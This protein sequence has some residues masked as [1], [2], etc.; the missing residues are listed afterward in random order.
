VRGRWNEVESCRTW[1]LS[2][3]FWHTFAM[4]VQPRSVCGSGM[5]FPL[6]SAG[7]LSVFCAMG[8]VAQEQT[9]SSKEEPIHT[10]HVYTNLI[11]VP[12]LVLSGNRQPVQTPISEKRFSVSIDYGPWF[13]VTHVRPEGND[14]ISISFLLDT[15]APNLLQGIANGIADLSPS[16]LTARDH[17]SIYVMGCGLTRSLNDVPVAGGVLKDGVDSAMNAWK[18]R[19]DRKDATCKRPVQLWD[20][21]G[22]LGTE[23]SKLPGRRVIVVVTDGRDRGSARSGNE[24]R[25]YLQAE[26]IAVFGVTELPV[27]VSQWNS[28]GRYSRDQ[29][30]LQEICERS[31]GVMIQTYAALTGKTLQGMITKMRGR[32]I[33]EF[34]RPSN[35]TAGAH[36]MRVKI[37]KGDDLFIRPSGTSIPLPDPELEKDPSTVHADTAVTPEQGNRRILNPK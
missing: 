4:A 13:P 30:S 14:P 6:W 20:T 18:A 29:I 15:N 35:S 9:A 28:F 26:G 1:H 32:Y 21:L 34:P 36:D 10:L 7:L 24:V 19:H 12:T 25:A 8:L 37:T 22:Y 11:Q 27:S 33:V 2:I 5:R 3:G 23:L 16:F 17:A 31:G